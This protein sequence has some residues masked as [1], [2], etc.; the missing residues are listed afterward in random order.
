MTQ[1]NMQPRS[2]FEAINLNVVD[3]SKD[4]VAIAQKIDAIHAALYPQP[5]TEED[6]EPDNTESL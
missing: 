1:Q 6:V 5:T 3:M 2:I 4:L